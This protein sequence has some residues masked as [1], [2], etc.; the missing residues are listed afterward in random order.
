MPD[1]RI[2]KRLIVVGFI[3]VVLVVIGC[4]RRYEGT[5]V[6]PRSGYESI[7]NDGGSSVPV[8]GK[9][10]VGI[11]S[12]YG[13]DFHGKP[14]ANGETFDMYAL[15]AAHKT[16]PFGSKVKV[17]RIS[18]GASIVVRINDRGPFVSGRIIDLSYS[19]AKKLDML[20]DG[21]AKVKIEIVE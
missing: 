19:A 1:I 2:Y 9:S 5:Y 3:A 14:T 12:Y 4:S 20:D 21:V 16:L 11:A 13:R 10:E 17:T 7:E 18:N 8:T 6:K 15:T